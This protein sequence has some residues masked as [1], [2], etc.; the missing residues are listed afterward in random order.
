MRELE[1]VWRV[2]DPIGGLLFG[3][4]GGAM[5]GEDGLES[6]RLLLHLLDGSLGGD[7]RRPAAVD[8]AGE[9]RGSRT[10]RLI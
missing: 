2:G 6:F 1:V 5:S 7:R 4:L 9:A 8:G 10:A 3:A